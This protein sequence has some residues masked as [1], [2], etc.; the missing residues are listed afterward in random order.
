M[1]AVTIVASCGYE[2]NLRARL[3]K[4]GSVKEGAGK[5]LVVDD[6]E[7]R[8][9]ITQNEL[10]I[11]ELEPAELEDISARIA[12]PIFYTVD[13]SNIDLCRRVLEAIADDPNV[14]VDNDHGVVLSGADFVAL[15]RSQPGWDWRLVA[16]A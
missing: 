11:Q 10:A 6:G 2:L 7:S 5:S 16:P 3:E 9:F 1:E 15:I 4:I 14:L 13:F 8:I 12:E